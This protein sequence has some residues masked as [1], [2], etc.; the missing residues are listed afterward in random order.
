MMGNLADLYND[1]TRYYDP[2][3]PT[4]SSNWNYQPFKSGVYAGGGASPSGLYRTAEGQ[5]VSN[6]ASYMGGEGAWS[7]NQPLLN[8]GGGNN[9]QTTDDLINEQLQQQAIA[10]RKAAW[11]AQQNS[12]YS[13]YF[14]FLN[15]PMEV[16]PMTFQ[17]DQVIMNRPTYNG[18]PPQTGIMTSNYSASGNFQGPRA[19][20]AL[21]GAAGQQV[22]LGQMYNLFNNP[23]LA[24]LASILFA[25]SNWLPEGSL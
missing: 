8:M 7:L 6:P 5:I 14:D 22:D 1:E 16:S 2:N 20:Q 12:M 17:G 23:Y 10:D 18:L 15:Q 19:P 4:T 21:P 11:D 13:G 25:N 3:N 24:Q 9:T